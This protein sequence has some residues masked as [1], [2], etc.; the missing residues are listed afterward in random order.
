MKTL[1]LCLAVSASSIAYAETKKIVA[2]TEYS[3]ALV[4]DFNTASPD[5][6]V[7]RVERANLLNEIVDADAIFG[8]VSAEM[9]RAAKKLKWVST[10]GA[11]V[12]AYLYPEMLNSSVVLTSSKI[13]MGPEVSEHALALLLGLTRSLNEFIPAKGRQEWRQ[14]VN[15]RPVELSGKTAVI[16]GVGGIGTQIA[17]KAWACGMRVIGV[18]PKDIP[19]T[20]YISRI[21]SPQLLDEVLPEADVLFISAPLT[22]QTKGMIGAKQFEELKTGAYFIAVSRGNIYD[23]DALVKALDSKRLAGAGLDVFSPE[24]LP[25]GH[26]LWNFEN[27]IITPHVANV[28]DRSDARK[29]L[30][31][32]ENIRRFARGDM[33]LIN[34]IDKQK[35][36]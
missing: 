9:F 22:P 13:T 5:V 20:P 11:G 1:I 30:V 23:A 7:L 4:D 24:P 28:S 31:H 36:Y 18:D 32:K 17:L 29:A 16:V 10:T 33:N 27:V 15:H 8:P 3:Q 34:V 2:T 19:A 14:A 25:K 12:D 35:G 6:K 21:V 26:P